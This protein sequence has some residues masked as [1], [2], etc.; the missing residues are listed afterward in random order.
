MSM[1]KL[2]RDSRLTI[3]AQ[4]VPMSKSKRNTGH[5]M[6]NFRVQLRQCGKAFAEVDWY[7][8]VAYTK[9]YRSGITQAVLEECERG[10]TYRPTAEM[11]FGDVA[12][13]AADVLRNRDFAAW[14]T[15][16]CQ[17]HDSIAAKASYDEAVATTIALV[18]TIGYTAVMNMA[19]EWQP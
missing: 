9:A 16:L 10:T 17:D 14:A 3:K 12:T 1:A 4:F 7:C 5:P 2:L 13:D 11:V 19:S 18:A 15:E 8:G 6:L